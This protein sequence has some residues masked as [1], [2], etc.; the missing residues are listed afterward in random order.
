MKIPVKPHLV[1]VIL[2]SFSLRYT[3]YSLFRFQILQCYV[4]SFFHLPFTINTCPKHF[5]LCYVE[6]DSPS[7]IL[8]LIHAIPAVATQLPVLT[9]YTRALI[10]VTFS[11]PTTNAHVFHFIYLFSF[12][13]EHQAQYLFTFAFYS[14]YLFPSLFFLSRLFLLLQPLESLM[15]GKFGYIVIFLF[16]AT[17]LLFYS[18][19]NFSLFLTACSFQQIIYSSLS[20]RPKNK[21]KNRN[22]KY[23]YINTNIN[24]LI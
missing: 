1:I 6:S 16:Q 5:E 22:H 21:N 23:T 7:W 19:F 12:G 9:P 3:Q 8:I 2:Q 18:I 15:K 17:Q 13:W 10:I 20:K 11:I 4:S 14:T 24:I